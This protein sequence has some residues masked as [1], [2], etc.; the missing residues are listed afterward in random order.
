MLESQIERDYVKWCKGGQ[1]LTLK[2]N[3]NWYANIPDRLTI[4]PDG[5]AFF[6]ELKRH[7]ETPRS[8]QVKRLALLER[9]GYRAYWADSLEDAIAITQL[10]YVLTHGRT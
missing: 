4:I 7:G 2:Q 3:A 9:M 6:L 8:G 5:G 10:E 1:I